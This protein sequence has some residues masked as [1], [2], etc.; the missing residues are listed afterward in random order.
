ME[1]LMM[2]VI[3][4]YRVVS[5]SGKDWITLKLISFYPYLECLIFGDMKYR[6]NDCA[7]Q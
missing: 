2:M 4:E 6:S 1:T 3:T 5:W 7:L